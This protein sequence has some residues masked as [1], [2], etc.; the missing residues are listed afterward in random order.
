MHRLSSVSAQQR[1]READIVGDDIY[2]PTWMVRSIDKTFIM[3]QLMN[4]SRMVL[5][6]VEIRVHTSAEFSEGNLMQ[7]SGRSV[8]SSPDGGS[9]ARHWCPESFRP[10]E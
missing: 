6:S 3:A 7:H 10:R 9:L 2:I 1:L 8:E 4:V 5:T